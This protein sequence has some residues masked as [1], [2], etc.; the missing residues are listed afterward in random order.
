VNKPK[1]QDLDLQPQQFEELNQRFYSNP[2]APHLYVRHRVR[3]L[4]LSGANGEALRKA[5]RGVRF[6]KFVAGWPDDD[7]LLEE[8]V[9]AGYVLAESVVLFH[10]AAEA[11]IRLVLAHLDHP[12]CPWLEVR[13]LT[14]N[15][16]KHAIDSLRDSLNDDAAKCRLMSVF[17]GAERPGMSPHKEVNEHWHDLADGVRE[18]LSISIAHLQ[19]E[20]DLYNAA[21]HGLVAVGGEDS[22]QVVPEGSGQAL[23]RADGH[24]LTYLTVD[25]SPPRWMRNV[26]WP[27]AEERLSLT[28]MASNYMENLWVTARARYTPDL[29]GQEAPNLLDSSI[30][31]RTLRIVATA[32]DN[33]RVSTFLRY[34]ND[35]GVSGR[36][37]YILNDYADPDPPPALKLG[38]E[39]PAGV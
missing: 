3:A 24:C 32:T 39:D 13:R 36:V 30:L 12:D 10:H 20:G 1:P 22:F 19:A 5:Q 7:P 35:T 16:Y 9:V 31:R 8:P 21:K 4:M 26:S 14:F 28:T 33:V 25:P 18:M 17:Y 15:E 11:L 23:V 37:A 6:G 2:A 27:N 34:I 29:A 38:G